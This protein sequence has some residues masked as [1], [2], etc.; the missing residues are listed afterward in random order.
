MDKIQE[1][2]Q[3]DYS[4]LLVSLLI[5]IF[6]IIPLFKYGWQ[7][8]EW[9]FVEKLGIQTKWKRERKQEHD[10]IVANAEAIGNLSKA[11]RE[12][13][14][15]HKEDMRKSD[16]NDG[17]IKKKLDNFIDES[18]HR[19]ETV[20]KELMDCVCKIEQSVERMHEDNV[21]HWNTSKEARSNIN[22]RFEKM[23]D[24]N[25]GRDDLI[26]AIANGNKELLGDKIDQK[27]DKY[28]KLDGIPANEVDEFESMCQAY[29]RLNGN[30]NR[31]RKYEHVKMHMTVI[32]VKTE[33][34]IN[35]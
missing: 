30:H 13:A 18:S 3:I 32:P 4:M 2:Q 14:E 8:L 23:I 10:M 19:N 7:G 31:K 21:S 1:L 6:V 16:E 27:F 11:V 34:I 25:K 20:R 33:L 15:Q 22:E 29:F 9:F 12:L 17:E 35:E 28:V 24:S 26:Q 5:M